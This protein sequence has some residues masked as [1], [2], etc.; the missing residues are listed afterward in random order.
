MA[1]KTVIGIAVEKIKLINEI[2]AA[3]A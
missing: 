1:I 2:V 3:K